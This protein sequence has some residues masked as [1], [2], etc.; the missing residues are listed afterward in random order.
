[1]RKEILDFLSILLIAVLFNS[2]I[3][4]AET[5]A[6]ENK[7]PESQSSLPAETLQSQDS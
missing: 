1:M 7:T 2:T 4:F 6:A 5:G 3:A